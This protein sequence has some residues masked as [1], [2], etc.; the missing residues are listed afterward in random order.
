MHGLQWIKFLRTCM[1][2]GGV[3]QSKRDAFLP[4]KIRRSAPCTVFVSSTLLGTALGR[5]STQ[6]RASVRRERIGSATAVS[7]CQRSTQWS[8]RNCSILLA[9]LTAHISQVRTLPVQTQSLPKT[10]DASLS[11][12]EFRQH[13]EKLGTELKKGPFLKELFRVLE[14]ASRPVTTSF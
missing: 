6:K 9:T 13:F 3:A 11:T 4:A 1:L 7:H 14:P 5:Q 10:C 8:A 2:I 12:V